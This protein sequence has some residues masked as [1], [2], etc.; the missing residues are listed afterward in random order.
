[1]LSAGLLPNLLALLTVHD[2]GPSHFKSRFTRLLV[3]Y[4][5]AEDAMQANKAVHNHR[6]KTQR[7]LFLP[8]GVPRSSLGRAREEEGLVLALALLLL[9]NL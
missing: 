1:M 2:P 4:V 8:S 9:L 6:K 5:L 3:A 7:T